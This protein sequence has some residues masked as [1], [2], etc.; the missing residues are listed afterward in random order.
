M[1]PFKSSD[2][3]TPKVKILTPDDDSDSGIVIRLLR[4]CDAAARY[5]RSPAVYSQQSLSACCNGISKASI[6]G[7][8]RISSRAVR[9]ADMQVDEEG[10][11]KSGSSAPALEWK[12]E[13]LERSQYFHTFEHTVAPRD[14]FEP[15]QVTVLQM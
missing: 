6:A 10:N 11:E 9:E 3:Y 8:F 7:A 12:L 15:G 5:E 1:L 2:G 14:L 13:R 4:Y